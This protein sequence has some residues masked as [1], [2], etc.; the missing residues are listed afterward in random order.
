MLDRARLSIVIS[1]ITTASLATVALADSTPSES[2]DITADADTAPVVESVRQEP[3][4]VDRLVEMHPAPTPVPESV[5]VIEEHDAR[6][7]RRQLK[8]TKAGARATLLTTTLGD[9][10]I[11]LKHAKYFLSLLPAGPERVH[12]AVFL[13]LRVDRRSKFNKLYTML[14]DTELEF[15]RDK[16]STLQLDPTL[17]RVH[18]EVVDADGRTIDSARVFIC[19]MGP[20]QAPVE[21]SVPTKLHQSG[22]EL[23]IWMGPEMLYSEKFVPTAAQRFARRLTVEAAAEPSAPLN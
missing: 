15:L 8:T 4:R 3:F 1:L 7:L 14:T 12:T 20:L 17:A 11:K 22:C 13:Y 18:V 16:M 23:Q 10:R 2:P 5:P 21:E 9:Q 6:Q 19:D